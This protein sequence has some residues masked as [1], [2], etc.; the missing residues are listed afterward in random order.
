M[1]GFL[2][3]RRDRVEA[4]RS[5]LNPVGYKI[6]LELIVKCGCKRVDEVPIRFEDR[7]Y[8]QSKLSLREQMN[9]LRHIF[10]LYHYRFRRRPA[11]HNR[12]SPRR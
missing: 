12:G 6:A 10:R 9:Y 4:V 8:G 1:A 11:S 5:E 2:A 3:I 7:A